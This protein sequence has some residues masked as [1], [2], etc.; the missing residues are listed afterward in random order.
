MPGFQMQSLYRYSHIKQHLNSNDI[1]IIG[2]IP[3]TWC[4]KFAK[5]KGALSAQQAVNETVNRG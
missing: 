2:Q 4:G 1:W 5:K 3:L